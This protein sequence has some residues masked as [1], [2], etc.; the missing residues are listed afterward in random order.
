M[1]RKPKNKGAIRQRK[2]VD[3]DSN[4]AEEKPAND[5]GVVEVQVEVTTV[6]KKT[7]ISLK[8]EEIEEDDG[9]S[10]KPQSIV[11]F[12]ID[13]GADS[14]FKVKK[15]KKK[16][17][18]LKRMHRLEEEAA[19]QAAELKKYEKEQKK[20]LDEK[21]NMEKKAKEQKEKRVERDKYLEKYRD[22]SAKHIETVYDE[23]LDAPYDI[24]ESDV[25]K[26]FSS[27]YG[28]IPDSRAVY[29]ARKRRERARREG[30]DGY[31]P[32]DDDKKIRPKGIRE[33]LVRED[34]N[35]DSD[36]ED[37]HKFYSS[38]DLL[39][40]E[41]ERRR[42]EQ[43]E[44]LAK[45]QGENLDENGVERAEDDEMEEWERQQIQKA[46]SRR[47]IGQL[48][49]EKHNVG[50]MFGQE[51]R[52]NHGDILEPESMDMDIDMD[53]IVENFKSK[54][55]GPENK[56]GS[57]TIE[58]TLA[59]MKLR[60]NDR[61]EALNARRR[62][63]LKMQQHLQEN[64]DMIIKIESELPRLS[65][66]FSMYQELRMYSRSLL[67][68]L[69]E[70]VAEINVLADKKRTL[71][72][73]KTERLAKRRR[74]DVRDQYAECSATS[75]GKNVN[76][77]RHGD[78]AV[79][80]AEREARRGRRRRE[81]ES[82]AKNATHEEGLSTDDEE[83]NSQV[84]ADTEANQ[85]V[86]A[87]VST[88]FADALDEYA[89]L[90]IVLERMIDWLSVDT[91]SFQD[92]YVHLCIPK[93]SSPYVRL[94]LISA[95]LLNKDTEMSR[96]QWYEDALLVG[97]ENTDVEKEHPVIVGLIPAI[98]EKVV[99]PFLTDVV[100]EEWEPLSLQQTRRLALFCQILPQLPTINDR[101][102]TFSA[103][104]E[105][106]RSKIMTAVD[107]DLFVPMFPPAAINNQATG[108]R[109]LLERQFWTAIKLIRSI[110][111]LSGIISLAARF[112]IIVETIV[113]RICIVALRIGP[114]ND[115]TCE[116]KLRALFEEMPSEV[117]AMGGMTSYQQIV[118]TLKMLAEEQK[119]A[120]RD[121]YRDIRKF[122][123]K[124]EH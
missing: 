26:K 113:S 98:V 114:K 38:R 43:N 60:M 40:G 68:C 102:K 58:D 119:N 88:I 55:S 71:N 90:R 57:I 41:E 34:E 122:I 64:K 5:S 52:A 42:E 16:V 80:A 15:N 51:G 46:V 63:V 93:L 32:L 4:D 86:D 115:V 45:E 74:R 6:V 76:T 36:E 123:E 82:V 20:E 1:F 101:S 2:A 31:I 21:I 17:E 8:E 29:E 78:A 110:N 103:L 92:A 67:E 83:T 19:A 24:D 75:S 7:V 94:Q 111:T 50:R 44:F 65:T 54:H 53:V 79:R 12:D 81:R 37:P 99:V 106:I 47:M 49:E 62:E 14:T 56:G 108:C 66:K 85:E 72:K 18:E 117:L 124:I 107:E 69:N 89:K 118:V 61:E 112:E 70:K 97:A 77:V 96:M 27:A 84:I 30:A 28:G 116:R 3:W 10:I 104:M 120:G 35:D 95:D 11:S 105:A 39:K 9:L 100:R 13:E 59:K 109:T 48:R 73:L 121:Y 23:D 91:K 22:S 25:S 87:L 33:R